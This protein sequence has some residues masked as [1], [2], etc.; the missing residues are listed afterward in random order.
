MRV[1][2]TFTEK[3][4]HSRIKTLR[5][6]ARAGETADVINFVVGA[7]AFFI[8]GHG[9][10]YQHPVLRYP[11]TVQHGSYIA[12]ITDVVRAAAVNGNGAVWDQTLRP[13]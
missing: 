6:P 11:Y 12:V 10:L 3:F 13:G 8:K 5:C 4:F 7:V 1:S 9:G 2:A